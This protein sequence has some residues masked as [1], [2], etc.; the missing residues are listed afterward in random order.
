MTRDEF[1]QRLQNSL[2][3][4][5]RFQNS[6]DPVDIKKLDDLGKE[7]ESLLPTSLRARWKKIQL[8]TETPDYTS[9]DSL[10]F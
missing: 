10:P 3:E 6:T 5:Q 2:Q 9:D 1:V 8:Y 4:L 7:I